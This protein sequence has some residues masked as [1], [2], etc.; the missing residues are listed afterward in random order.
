MIGRA[1][2][3]LSNLMQPVAL[4]HRAAVVDDRGDVRAFLRVAVQSAA[5]GEDPLA[6]TAAAAAAVRQSATIAFE[7]A[8]MSG[9][10]GGGRRRRRQ[11]NHLGSSATAGY[12]DPEKSAG[13]AF[14][15]FKCSL[16]FLHSFQRES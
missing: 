6:G 10:G 1:F 13:K 15:A 8:A 12:G 5:D 2:V 16:T 4:L 14:K 11:G 7:A 3:Y 9:G